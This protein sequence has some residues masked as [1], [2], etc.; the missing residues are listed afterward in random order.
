MNRRLPLTIT[1]TIAVLAVWMAPA[2]GARMAGSAHGG[3][4]LSTSM[5][6]DQ[7]VPPNPSTATGTFAATANPGHGEL[8]YE[9][10][11]DGLTTPA[12]NAHIHQ[13]PAGVNGPVVVP[14]T[15]TPDESGATSDCVDIGR[16]LAK[17]LIKNPAGYYVNVHTSEY[18][19]GEIRG[20]L[21]KP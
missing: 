2:L 3:A 4:P 5:T 9:L 8:C 18:Q 10:A 17:K 6:G 21:S 15:V 12:R 20:Q 19:G 14:L 11:W 13:A 1:A 16:A 7:E